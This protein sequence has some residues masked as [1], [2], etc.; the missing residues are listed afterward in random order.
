MS[1]KAIEQNGILNSFIE[2]KKNRLHLNT[3]LP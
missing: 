2:T 3:V 1:E